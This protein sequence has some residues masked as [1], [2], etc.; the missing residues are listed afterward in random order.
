MNDYELI[1]LVQNHKDGV[2]FNKLLS[3]YENLMFKYIRQ[4][5][6]SKKDVDDYL[7][8]A[9]IVLIKCVN[10]YSESFNKTFTRYFELSLKRRF[11]TLLNSKKNKYLLVDDI[12]I[13][14][15]AHDNYD[16]FSEHITIESIK[17]NTT[18]SQL[19]DKIFD[20]HFKDNIK[21]KDIASILNIDIKKIYN[22]VYKIRNKVKEKYTNND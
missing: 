9:R 12:D 1:Y 16:A 22:I 13:L 15:M 18:S 3:K 20:M 17:L 5:N 21:L 6:V 10:S 2:S 19:E 8:E 4:Y 11:W 7:Q 14:C